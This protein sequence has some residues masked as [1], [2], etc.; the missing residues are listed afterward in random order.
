[1]AVFHRLL[2]GCAPKATD[3]GAPLEPR[4]GG[5]QIE[6][7]ILPVAEMDKLL[8]AANGKIGVGKGRAEARQI[9]DLFRGRSDRT[10]SAVRTRTASPSNSATMFNSTSIQARNPPALRMPRY[11][12]MR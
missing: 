10:N 4:H 1:M 6:P 12:M 5:Q 3:E 11:S 9:G 8:G 2:A 7:D